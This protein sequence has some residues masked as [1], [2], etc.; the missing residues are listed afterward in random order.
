MLNSILCRVFARSNKTASR[1]QSIVARGIEWLAVLAVALAASFGWSLA[2]GPQQA[3]LN[4]AS[5]RLESLNGRLRAAEKNVQSEAF[6]L[7]QRE[8]LQRRLKLA[9]AAMPSEDRFRWFL[10]KVTSLLP[11]EG[12]RLLDIARE[13]VLSKFP[14][15][16]DYPLTTASFPVKLEGTKGALVTFLQRAETNMPYASIM[17]VNVRPSSGPK[18]ADDLTHPLD[19]ELQ[20]ALLLAPESAG[21]AKP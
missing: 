16:Y 13:P 5:D 8:E 17:D 9:R 14:G 6:V 11:R 3:A 21:R 18:P 20:I 1:S 4:A 12:L 15:F 2:Y 7:A 19:I 10:E